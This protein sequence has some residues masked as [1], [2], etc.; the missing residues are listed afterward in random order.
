MTVIPPS[1]VPPMAPLLSRLTIKLNRLDRSPGLVVMLLSVLI[2]G[3]AGLGVVLFHYLIDSFDS[4]SHALVVDNLKG[5]LHIQGNWLF[6]LV[7]I[8]GGIIVGIMRWY[9]QDFGPNMNSMIAATQ[10]GRQVKPWRGLVKMVA[11]SVSLG[12][13]ASLGPEGPS[14]EIGANM[15]MFLGQMLHASQERQRLLLGAGAAAGI[16]AGFN[17]P[18]AGVFFALELVLGTTFA[19]SAVSVVVLAAVVAS[20]VAQIGLGARPAFA[21]P[22]YEVK[23][24]FELPLYLLLGGLA[25]LVAFSYTQ[26][27][28]FAREAFQGNV[29]SLSWLGKIPRCLTPVIGGAVVGIVAIKFPQVTGIGYETIE[30]MLQDVEFSMVLLV[31]ILVIKMLMTAVS[32]GSGLVGGLFAP[33]MFLGATL[34]AIYGKS[35]VLLF[36][37]LAGL[38]AAPPAYAMVGMAAVLASSARAPLTSILLMFELTRDYRI[39]LPVMACVGLSIWAIERMNPKSKMPDKLDKL[40]L[41][42]QP[43]RDLDI[44]QNLHVRDAMDTHYLRLSARLDILAAGLKLTQNNCHSALVVDDRDEL[45]GIITLHDL[46][47]AI[48]QAEAASQSS[49]LA[50]DNVGSI[51]TKHL[52]FADID[53]PITTAIDRMNARGLHQL[54]VTDRTHPD[55]IVGILQQERIALACSVAA[56]RQALSKYQL[57]LPKVAATV[58]Q[59][60]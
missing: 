48:S 39:V 22:V 40:A 53:E 60:V 18:I 50:I 56:T 45:L 42:V 1:S 12:T 16:A 14:V 4:S 23:S 10:E 58:E 37:S 20:L 17:A 21:L 57:L 54:P 7:P 32:L 29:S 2:G 43:D 24:L 13:G 26:T 46:S 59:A 49:R 44:L 55:T 52:L 41:S 15:G 33:S 9:W 28:D 25:S 36:P 30:A 3:T 27:V 35:L 34:G 47:R 51:C 5:L 11:A 19:T 6:A 8:L 31:S 38:I